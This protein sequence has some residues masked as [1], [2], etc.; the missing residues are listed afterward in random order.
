[1]RRT[2]P[3]P[4]S[5]DLIL[6]VILAAGCAT[7]YAGFALRLARGAF[8]DYINLAF[9]FDPQIYVDLF[10]GTGA[11]RGN[12]KHPLIV[13]LR[14]FGWLLRELGLAPAAAAGLLMALCGGA[15]VGVVFLILRSM[16]VATTLALALAA[17]FAVS[18]S[19]VITAM[20]PEAYG[21]A[22]LG[23]ALGWLLA[24]RTLLTSPERGMGWGRVAAT[25]TAFGITITNVVQP[26]LAEA[27]IRLRD[28][29]KPRAIM[30][31]AIFG[32]TVAAIAVALTGLAWADRVPG[33]LAD[34]LAVVREAY[35]QRTVGERTGFGETIMRLLGFAVVAPRFATVALP[36][37]IAMLDFRL[38][39]FDGLALTATLVWH[40]FWAAGAAAMLTQPR[41]RILAAG[42]AGALLFNVVLHLDFQFRGSLFLYAAHVHLGLFVLGCGMAPL[43]RPGSLAAQAYLAAVLVLV[44]LVGATSFD[45]AAALAVGFDTVNVGCTAPCRL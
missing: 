15:T 44:G 24:V 36:E 35:W 4:Y 10:A 2:G 41:L 25:V 18:A 3:S 1:M 31:L 40:G 22:A 9:D 5:R 19:Q 33:L 39:E 13:L 43:L 42:L 21:P 32:A 23:L 38:P 16:A 17:L 37:G 14:P 45:R 11:E 27:L 34:P 30:R 6:A 29:D 8:S 7:V 12:V 28:P 26:L 20:V